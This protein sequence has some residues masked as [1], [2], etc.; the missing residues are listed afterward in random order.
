MQQTPSPTARAEHALTDSAAMCQLLAQCRE[1]KVPGW[2]DGSAFRSHPVG[3]IAGTIKLTNHW[4]CDDLCTIELTDGDEW[5]RNVCND[6]R[7][8]GNPHPKPV[9]GAAISVWRC[10]KWAKPEFE[11]ALKSRVVAL[12][13]DAAR[14]IEQA[15][16]ERV[17]AEQEQQAKQ[18]AE[19]AAIEQR[20]MLAAREAA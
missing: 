9:S 1:Y 17:R 16:Q 6:S 12:L 20:A 8:Y 10:G 18:K 11:E 13:S 14:H 2:W 4:H 5:D 3:L 15:W 7:A 19:R